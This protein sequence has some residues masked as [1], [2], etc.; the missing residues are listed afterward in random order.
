MGVGK[1]CVSAL[2]A[3]LLV[4]GTPLQAGE[5]TAQVA[6]G[7]GLRVIVPATLAGADLD[8][9]PLTKSTDGEVSDSP[10]AR[11]LEF[12]DTRGAGSPA[13][14]LNA[15]RPLPATLAARHLA[16][17]S[18]PSEGEVQPDKKEQAALDSLSPALAFHERDSVF[19][20]KVIDVPQAYLG[21]HAGTV[22]VISRRALKLLSTPELQAAVAHEIGHEYFALDYDRARHM[23][24]RDG[25]REIEHRC[26]AIALLTALALGRDPAHLGRAVR[27]LT[28]SNEV[29][30]ATANAAFYPSL[31]ERERFIRA[32]LRQQTVSEVERSGLRSSR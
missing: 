26:D 19:V 23:T 3:S 15:L 17:A 22:L 12:F 13:D 7:E 29:V 4:Q 5:V 18:L 1:T 6:I 28:G 31:K 21:L 27:K 8:R 25:R 20:I 10:A 9:G 16:L 14:V 2:V 30:G 32:F 11:A 24:D